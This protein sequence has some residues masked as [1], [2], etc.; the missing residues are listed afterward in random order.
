[1]KPAVIPLDVMVGRTTYP[2][3]SVCKLTQQGWDVTFD[4]DHV[5]MFHRKSQHVVRDLSF[6]HDT[7]WIRVVPYEG[8]DV[9][10]MF[11]RWLRIVFQRG[12][13]FVP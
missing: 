2:I 6:W 12:T 7:P 13:R 9:A 5:R 3:I 10:S 8:N 1:M 4:Q 11:L